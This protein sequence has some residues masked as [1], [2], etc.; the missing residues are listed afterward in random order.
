MFRVARL[1]RR[2][3]GG[4][5]VDTRSPYRRTLR[6]LHAEPLERR[7]LMAVTNFYVDPQNALA[8]DT[9]PGTIDQPLKTL[10]G[11]R[12]KVRAAN[13][14]MTDDIVVNL[15]KGVYDLSAGPLVL[16]SAD[17]GANAHDVIWRAYGKEKPV[18]SGGKEI[19]GTWTLVPGSGGI[20]RLAGVTG[21]DAA[22]A[23]YIN[24][25]RAERA[26]AEKFLPGAILNADGSIRVSPAEIAG[27]R[28]PT[29]IEFI[30]EQ[31]NWRS[32]NALVAGVTDNG[33]GTA[34]IRLRGEVTGNN[35]K[36]VLPVGI[37][38]A[39]ELLDQP[40]EFYFDKTEHAL[41]Y[42]PRRGENLA[43]AE[44]IAPL[45]D[46]T[47]VE[48]AGDSPTNPITHVQFVGL[49]FQYTNYDYIAEAGWASFG[50]SGLGGS[51]NHVPGA[52]DLNRAEQIVISGNTFQH[53]GANAI[54][55]WQWVQ[56]NTIRGNTIDD[57]GVCGISIGDSDRESGDLNGDPTRWVEGNV[58][59][60]NLI[61]R[62]GQDIAEGSGMVVAYGRDTTITHNEVADG[63]Y[64]GIAVG[65]GWSGAQTTMRNNIVAYNYVHDVLK[66]LP[67]G[68]AIYL[69]GRQDGSRVHDNYI[70]NTRAIKTLVSA[71]GAQATAKIESASGK[72]SQALL[73]FGGLIGNGPGQVPAG[74]K[75]VS[76][77]LTLSGTSA[78][79][80]K[81]HHV[82]RD[83]NEFDA[84]WASWNA[85]FGGTDGVSANKKD[86]AS[87]IAATGAPKIKGD[88]NQVINVTTSVKAWAGGAAN[89]GWV[90]KAATSGSTGFVTS[91]SAQA[92]SRPKL[93]VTYTIGK[94]A[95][96]T[97]FQQGFNHY[98][99]AQDTYLSASVVNK[100]NFISA[101]L[102]LEEGSS[103]E[104]WENN[105]LA[106]V[107]NWIHIWVS[108]DQARA[109]TPAPWNNLIRNNLTNS[110]YAYINNGLNFTQPQA[111]ATGFLPSD[112]LARELASKSGSSAIASA[113]TSSQLGSN[114]VLAKW[115]AR[116][117]S[118]I[119][120]A[121][122]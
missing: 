40:G 93:T 58:I 14:N 70:A 11:A 3:F 44:V 110:S 81:L 12:D 46:S 112:A 30:Y 56:H 78:T 115:N 75:I 64:S 97:S 48:L 66:K 72:E 9:G 57:V 8:S 10:V 84:D 2:A 86:A 37:E 5:C 22:R 96:T 25:V 61:T 34:T 24:G 111:T 32:G 79:G 1:L 71:A 7:E 4:S 13:D 89:H 117:K 47:L 121:G 54:D 16:T 68:G 26:G 119:A 80:V 42:L 103:F 100:A 41:Y 15:R 88:T 29:D 52:I 17:S 6:R 98:L 105:V 45:A 122:V 74:A 92:A 31:E 77:T 21:L 49:T 90:L 39:Y 63:P 73:K 120:A 94:I 28:N 114:L 23:I 50:Q 67:D 20:Y 82:L 55:L 35:G 38:N 18:L 83:W 51:P 106:N 108:P 19:E 60:R 62:F 27:W 53:L 65:W 116:A 59:D 36:K 87:A 99:G 91:D 95:Y 43:K 107:T 118:I 69:V 102:Y 76:A 104:T 113:F 109:G 85:N 101:G 33:D